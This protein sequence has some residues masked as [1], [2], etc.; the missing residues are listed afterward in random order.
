MNTPLWSE[1]NRHTNASATS[2]AY[3]KSRYSSLCT[4]NGDFFPRKAEIKEGIKLVNENSIR[5]V[6]DITKIVKLTEKKTLQN[7][8]ITLNLAL[9]YGSKEEITNACKELA[10]KKN[11]KISVNNLEKELYTR[12]IPDPEILIRTGGT[13]RLSNFLLWQLAYT[14]IFF[15]DK[16]WPD[17]NKNDFN[18]VII[19]FNKIKRNFGKI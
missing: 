1:N 5:E 19:K 9:N 8:K 4:P 13:K 3:K 17:F 16:L 7:K 2:Y 11:K 10:L 14:E 18:K 6:K 15:M 12:N